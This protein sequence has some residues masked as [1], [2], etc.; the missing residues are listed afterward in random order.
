VNALS[1]PGEKAR[2]RGEKRVPCVSG[3]DQRRERRMLEARF[4]SFSLGTEEDIDRE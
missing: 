1:L 4:W 2:K 3:T